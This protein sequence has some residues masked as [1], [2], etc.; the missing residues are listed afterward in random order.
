MRILFICCSLLLCNILCGQ[1]TPWATSGSI[2]IGTTTPSAPLEVKVVANNSNTIKASGFDM[3][4]DGTRINGTPTINSQLGIGG[5]GYD[6]GGFTWVN[7][8]FNNGMGLTAM[9]KLVVNYG[10][11]TGVKFFRVLSPTTNLG[12]F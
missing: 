1:N 11:T 2:G 5:V 4:Y 10:Q 12:N 9:Q 8:G 6:M 7:D 3:T